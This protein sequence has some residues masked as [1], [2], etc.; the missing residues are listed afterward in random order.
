M[1]V[2]LTEAAVSDLQDAQ[3]YY[4]SVDPKLADDFLDSVDAVID[5]LE[6]FPRGAPPVEGFP[7]MRRARLRMFPYGVFYQL[8][9]S[10]D[11]LI[12]RVLHTRRPHVDALDVA[13]T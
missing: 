4:A 1:R 10:G 6:M 2:R 3:D 5:R 8:E 7:G 9:D 13:S 11:A 12:V